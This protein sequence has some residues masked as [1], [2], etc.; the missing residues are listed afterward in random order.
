M[1][2]EQRDED[3]QPPRAGE[4]PQKAQ[5]QQHQCYVGDLKQRILTGQIRAKKDLEFDWAYVSQQIKDS[6]CPSLMLSASL[7]LSSFSC[8]P[9]L[10]YSLLC[11]PY[12]TMESLVLSILSFRDQRLLQG[13]WKQEW[14]SLLFLLRVMD[15][16]SALL[17]GTSVHALLPALACAHCCAELWGLR[18]FTLWWGDRVSPSSHHIT[19]ASFHSVQIQ[20]QLEVSESR[21]LR[22]GREMLTFSQGV[23]GSQTSSGCS[24]KRPGWPAYKT[25]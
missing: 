2:E 23:F 10:L 16:C 11:F 18:S 4:T 8:F 19:L 15:L 22:A 17:M 7:S 5:I 1:L 13:G 25:V 6:R 24:E 20:P 21:Q 9:T 12:D 3:H 14:E